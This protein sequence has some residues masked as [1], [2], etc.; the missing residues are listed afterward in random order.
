[1]NGSRSTYMRKGYLLTALAAAVLLAASSGT[2]VSAQTDAELVMSGMVKAASRSTRPQAVIEG[3]SAEIAVS[4]R[5]TGAKTEHLD[6]DDDPPTVDEQACRDDSTV[7]ITLNWR[8]LSPGAPQPRSE[9]HHCRPMARKTSISTPR[10]GVDGKVVIQPGK[11]PMTITIT[12]E[13]PARCP[14]KRSTK[15]TFF[16]DTE[17]ATAT[18]RTRTSSWRLW[19]DA[20]KFHRPCRL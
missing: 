17:L 3:D 10:V 7:V 18:P 16:V 4:V 2:C 19:L 6:N 20:R 14:R 15:Q 8:T 1:M 12:F 9:D 13:V 11:Q 5:A